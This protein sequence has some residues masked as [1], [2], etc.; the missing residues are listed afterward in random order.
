M[1][2]L[3]QTEKLSEASWNYAMFNLLIYLV[4]KQIVKRKAKEA[5]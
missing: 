2:L 3:E 5:A 4:R 1:I